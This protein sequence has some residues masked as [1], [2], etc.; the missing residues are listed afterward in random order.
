MVLEGIGKCVG[1]IHKLGILCQL[2]ISCAI[3]VVRTA[4]FNVMDVIVHPPSIFQLD[5]YLLLYLRTVRLTK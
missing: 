4:T 3:S 5:K 1:A 2:L